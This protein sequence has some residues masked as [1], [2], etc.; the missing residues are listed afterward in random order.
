MRQILQ[1]SYY[2]NYCIDHNQIFQSDRDTQVLTVGGPNMPQ[3]NPGWRTATIWKNQKILISSQQIDQF[4]RNLA[5]WCVKPTGPQQRTEFRH[6]NNPRWRQQES[7]KLEKS[8]Y[9]CNGMTD[10]DE[11][12]YSDASGPSGHRQPI[13]FCEFDN[14][15]WRRPPSWKIENS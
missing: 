10:L 11:I 12:W 1:C 9:L 14:P 6:F 15:R 7:W 2:K 4:W 3:T 13:K 5:R 8:W